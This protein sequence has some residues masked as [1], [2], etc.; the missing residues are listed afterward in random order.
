M[1]KGITLY[2]ALIILTALT[3]VLLALIN[4]SVSQIKI[5]GVQGDSENAFF[6]ADTGIERVLYAIYK[7]EYE[8]VSGKCPAYSGNLEG[9][10]TYEVCIDSVTSTIIRSTGAYQ[11]IQRKIEIDISS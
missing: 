8:P 7:E 11:G 1:N 5:T 10:A 3:G 6:A 2:F 9:G 4:I